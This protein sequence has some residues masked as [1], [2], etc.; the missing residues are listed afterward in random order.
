MG[1]GDSMVAL[2][3]DG[4]CRLDVIDSGPEFHENCQLADYRS[5]TWDRLGGLGYRGKVCLAQADPWVVGNYPQQHV[6][7]WAE[8]LSAHTLA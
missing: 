2:V 1:N 7:P 6:S 4:R 5:W 8:F 3:K